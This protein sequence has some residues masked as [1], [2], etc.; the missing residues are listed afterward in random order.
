M[1]YPYPTSMKNVIK[2][3]AAAM[4]VA[5]GLMTFTVAAQAAGTSAAAFLK[6]GAGA[7][8]EGMGRA[9]SSVADD[10]TAVYW[11]PAGL[12]QLETAELA[13]MQ[14][15]HFVD[16]QYQFVAGARPFGDNVF[17]LSIYRLDYGTIDRYTAADVKEGGF[18]AGSLAANLS[19]GRKI[20]DRL[21]AGVTAKFVQETLESETAGTFAADLGMIYKLDRANVSAVIQHAGAGLKMVS[22]SAPLPLTVRLGASQKFVQDKLLAAVEISKANDSDASFHGG[23]EYRLTQIIAL[24]GGYTAT[25]GQSTDL[26]GLTGA[27]AGLGMT[28]NRF[29]LDYSVSPFGDLGLSHRFSLGYKF[30]TSQTY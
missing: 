23:V 10:V 1:G 8:A 6:L 29:N 18:S 15:T 5:A 25:P 17:G 16:T 9:F 20:G 11:N 12:A 24:R 7:R 22:E 3:T 27:N 21:M 13:A 28:F 4:S 2:N 14:N 30:A 26:G 19:M